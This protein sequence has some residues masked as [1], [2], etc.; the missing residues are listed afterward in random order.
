MS[1]RNLTLLCIVA[2]AANASPLT[3]AVQK[4]PSP[5]FEPNEGHQHASNR[6]IARGMGYTVGFDD[7]ASATYA[8]QASQGA[9]GFVR[10]ELLGAQSHPPVAGEGRL[11][12]FTRYYGGKPSETARRPPI[13]PALDTRA[14]TRASISYGTPTRKTL[15]TSSGWGPEPMRAPSASDLLTILAWTLMEKAIW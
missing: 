1:L 4:L 9:S 7:D 8:L 10:M 5:W 11:P 6:F 13:I 12:S 2:A 14:Y 3:P 15:N